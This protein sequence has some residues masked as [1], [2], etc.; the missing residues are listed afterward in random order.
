MYN[1][2]V[3]GLLVPGYQ[4]KF[5]PVVTADVLQWRGCRLCEWE[6][7]EDRGVRMCDM[8]ANLF[9]GASEAQQ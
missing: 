4:Q 8:A 3:V 9:S 2:A 1:L 5:Q 6:G 7:V